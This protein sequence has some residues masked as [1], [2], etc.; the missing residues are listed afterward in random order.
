[1]DGASRG[2]LVIEDNRDLREA[3]AD[4]LTDEGHTVMTASNGKDALAILEACRPA[5]VVLDLMMPQ[6]SGFELLEVMKR[7]PP[8]AGI[9]VLVV[10]A[11]LEHGVRDRR[12]LQKPVNREVLVREVRVLLEARVRR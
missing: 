8:L 1:V 6:M 7:E 5:L 10:T 9:P 11:S 12:V 2:V 3:I 4:V